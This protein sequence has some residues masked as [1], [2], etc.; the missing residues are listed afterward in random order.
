MR[1]LLILLFIVVTGVESAR[2]QIRRSLA[3]QIAK[4]TRII[5]ALKKNNGDSARIEFY[6]ADGNDASNLDLSKRKA[7][8]VKNAL[9]KEFG[10]DESRMET[11]VKGESEPI[12]KND[13]PAGKANN[14]RV[15]FLKT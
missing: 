5:D 7:A 2:A 6:D 15:E 12:D 10:I 9:T 4:V 3:P 8:S 11:D 13:T 14:R 1:F